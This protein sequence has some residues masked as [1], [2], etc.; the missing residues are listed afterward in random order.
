MGH[1]ML[2][3]IMKGVSVVALLLGFLWNFPAFHKEWSVRDGGYLELLNMVVCL[4]A[5]LVV[6][7]AFRERKYFWAAGFVAIAV[8]FNPIVPVTLSRKTFL[9]L[10]SVCVVTFLV[11]LA[12]WKRRPILSIPPITNRT[13]GSES[14]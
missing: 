12:L 9:W 10:D 4:T 13:P 8:L 2:T 3:R 1:A 5:L 7:Q 11:S 14:L 6:A